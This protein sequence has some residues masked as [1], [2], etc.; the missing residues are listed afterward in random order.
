VSDI[1]TNKGPLAGIHAGLSIASNPSAFLI[2]CDMPFPNKEIVMDQLNSFYNSDCEALIPCLNEKIEPLHAVYSTSIFAELDTYLRTTA[3]YSIR[4]YF[5][6][7]R[8]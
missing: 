5:K 4:G 2:S 6:K 1:F 3:D 7:S 8:H